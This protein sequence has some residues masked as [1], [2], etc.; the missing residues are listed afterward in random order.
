MLKQQDNPT[1]IN[2]DL[3]FSVMGEFLLQNDTQLWNIHGNKE[4]ATLLASSVR[5][6]CFSSPSTVIISTA[7][8]EVTESSLT[9]V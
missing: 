4:R 3:M 5:R 9:E 6:S 2:S 7:W 8:Q 1:L